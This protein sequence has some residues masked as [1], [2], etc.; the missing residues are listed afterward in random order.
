MNSGQR[1]GKEKESCTEKPSVSGRQTAQDVHDVLRCDID[2][3]DLVLCYLYL[4]NCNAIMCSA[5]IAIWKWQMV[6]RMVTN[7]AL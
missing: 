4:G 1:P 7:D 5:I 2:A 6:I 3:C